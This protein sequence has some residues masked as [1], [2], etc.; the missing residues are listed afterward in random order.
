MRTLLLLTNAQDKGSA[1]F[2]PPYMLL[3]W[4]SLSGGVYI[5]HSRE[6]YNKNLQTTLSN[7]IRNAFGFHPDMPLD[8]QKFLV[9]I[10]NKY[11]PTKDAFMDKIKLIPSAAAGFEAKCKEKKWSIQ[12]LGGVKQYEEKN[13]EWLLSQEDFR[14]AFEKSWNQYDKTR[15]LYNYMTARGLLE[16]SRM[17]VKTMVNTVKKG[18]DHDV[19]LHNMH[20]WAVTWRNRM[21]VVLQCVTV[22]H[23]E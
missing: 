19:I 2:G 8:C 11:S 9:G 14:S 5:L 16:Q 6:P 7:G 18:I 22:V 13:Y 10:G 4:G 15:A 20:S 12:T 17:I 21:H 23:G 1:A 3:T